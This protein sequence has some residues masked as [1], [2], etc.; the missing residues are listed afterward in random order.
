MVE[1]IQA[2]DTF[3]DVGAN[4]GMIT[5]MAAR[6]VGPGGRV[7]AF[8][9]NPVAM[10]HLQVAIQANHLAWV[11]PVDV[12]LSD[13]PAQLTLRVSTGRDSGCGTFGTVLPLKGM[14][15]VEQHPA[16]T[17][18]GN[19]VLFGV[20]SAPL[21]IIVD[22][23]GLEQRV[24]NGLAKTIRE[25][26]PLIIT[27]AL[28]EFLARAG[29]TVSSLSDAMANLGYEPFRM[30]LSGLLRSRK[31]RLRPIRLSEEDPPENVVWLHPGSLHQE[32]LQPWMW[33][34]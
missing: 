32:R 12:G 26:R 5:L 3:V 4:A 6:C 2:G 13:S 8:E 22:V 18:R 23:E 21:M 11:P 28:E 31:L 16:F 9:P 27:E 10:A 1:A 24:I 7:F 33:I 25:F 29:S 19:D 17:A 34:P 30:E 14:A 15:S 20:V